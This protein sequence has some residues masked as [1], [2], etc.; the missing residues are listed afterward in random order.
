[1]RMLLALLLLKHLFPDTL[2]AML[3]KAPAAHTQSYFYHCRPQA[4]RRVAR[5]CAAS[6]KAEG[7]RAVHNSLL[8]PIIRLGS[9]WIYKPQKPLLN[10]YSRS[11]LQC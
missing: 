11:M 9:N 4:S 1:M 7:H 2:H 6:R 8:T 3:W 5:T 10:V